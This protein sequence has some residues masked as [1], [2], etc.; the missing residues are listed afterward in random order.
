MIHKL[1]TIVIP[2]K[3]EEQ[4]IGKTSTNHTQSLKHLYQT[5]SWQHLKPNIKIISKKTLHQL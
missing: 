4:Y 1:V 5:K 2:C 3:N